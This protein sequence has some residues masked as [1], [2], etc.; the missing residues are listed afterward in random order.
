MNK[1]TSENTDDARL[2]LLIEQGDRAAFNVIYEKYWAKAY[3]SAYKRL[4]DEDEAKNVVQEIFINIWVRRGQPIENL[5]AYLNIAVRNQVYKVVEKQKCSTPF[6]DAFE[7]ISSPNEGAD[8]NIL[9]Q[10]FYSYYENLLAGLP[11]KRQQIFRLRFHEDQTT[12]AIADQMGIS[13]KTV[14]NQLGKAIEQLRMVLFSNFILV[15]L[16]LLF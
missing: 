11:P 5:P 9:W 4:R 2:L 7:S 10:E 6:L 8:R 15:I 1:I 14:Q 16:L 12:K 13:R 3:S